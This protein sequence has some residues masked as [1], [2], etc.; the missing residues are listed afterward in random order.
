MVTSNGQRIE[1][2][3][4]GDIPCLYINKKKNGTTLKIT[5]SQTQVS[6]ENKFNLFSINKAMR[7]G[8]NLTGDINDGLTLHKGEEEIHFNIKIPKI[9]SH[10]WAGCFIQ[11]RASTLDETALATLEEELKQEN[12]NEDALSH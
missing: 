9:K 3:A 2:T 11:R 6:P 7:S 12:N 10:L 4:C 1:Q 8:W 5:I